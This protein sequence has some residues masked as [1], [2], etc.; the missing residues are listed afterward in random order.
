MEISEDHECFIYKK[1]I[2]ALP[3]VTIGEKQSVC[4]N[5]ASKERNESL[6]CTAEQQEHQDCHHKYCAPNQ[7]AKALKQIVLQDVATNTGQKVLRSSK[8]QFNFS[9]DCF[10]LGKPAIFGRKRKGSDVVP[11]RTVETRDT[12]LAV[13]QERW[14]IGQIL[15]KQEFYTFMIC[16]LQTQYIIVCSANF[17]TMKQIPA[18]HE[19]EDSSLKKKGRPPE[20]QR[21]EHSLRLPHF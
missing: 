7:I 4:I 10:F 11:V 21:T 18:I 13:C 5:K 15:C 16:M 12:V 1:P 2:G 20:K 3:K 17:R 6:N 19:H 9:T 8:R 14:I